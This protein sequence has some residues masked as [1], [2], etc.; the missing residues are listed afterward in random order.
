VPIPAPKDARTG[1]Q[2]EDEE[3]WKEEEEKEEGW[4]RAGVDGSDRAAAAASASKRE[5][6]GRSDI[7]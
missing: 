3:A 7:L 1:D 5:V 6:A 2:R 4:C